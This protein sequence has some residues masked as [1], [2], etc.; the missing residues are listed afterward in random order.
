LVT[1]R[2]QGAIF[3]DVEAVLF[4]KDGTIADSHHFLLKLAQQRIGWICQQLPDLQ[5]SLER[6]FGVQAHQISPTGL[7]AVGTRRETEIAA[8]A[9]ITA[10]G[11]EWNQ[12]LTIARQ[13]FENADRQMGRKADFTPLFDGCAELLKHL[14]QIGLKLG[15]L[16]ADTT[17]NVQDFVQRYDLA[18]YL[19]LQQGTDEGVSK[20]DPQLFWQAC[21]A[22]NVSPAKTL[23]VGDSSADVQMAQA[24]GAI[25]CAVATWGW[26]DVVALEKLLKAF[27]APSWTLCPIHHLSELQ[28]D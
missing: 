11:L 8:A 15:I 20:P 1:I 17:V 26:T 5:A 7:M 21:H 25:G 14:H 3:Q 6:A 19:D 2:C 22:L 9:F 4:D 16:S 23:M 27:A 24:A 18:P 28:V 13:A 10:T 12:S